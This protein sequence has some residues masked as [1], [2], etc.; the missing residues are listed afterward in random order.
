MKVREHATLQKPVVL[1][2]AACSA[3]RTHLACDDVV[4]RRLSVLVAAVGRSNSLN[5]LARLLF[6]LRI[7]SIVVRRIAF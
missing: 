1:W 2:T 7:L 3:L 6:C 4:L 5:P